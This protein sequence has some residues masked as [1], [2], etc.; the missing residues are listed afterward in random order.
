M[1]I[2]SQHGAVELVVEGLRSRLIELVCRVCD[3]KSDVLLYRDIVDQR[4]TRRRRASR[5]QINSV[6]VDL[7]WST[8]A[9]CHHCLLIGRRID[10]VRSGF[11]FLRTDVLLQQLSHD[12]SVEVVLVE[13]YAWNRRIF[14]DHM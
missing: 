1:E 6:V 12:R 9:C 8:L 7:I 2:S 5:D 13:L 3:G 11:V 14:L 10:Q 4:M